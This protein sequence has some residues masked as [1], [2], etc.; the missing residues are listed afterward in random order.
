M[1]VYAA[2]RPLWHRAHRFPHKRIK[3]KACRAST[4]YPCDATSAD[5]AP[6]CTAMI[7]PDETYLRVSVMPPKH[8]GGRWITVRLCGACAIHLGLATEEPPE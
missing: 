4:A 5:T 8:E 6:D 7:D 3:K 1:K 2:L